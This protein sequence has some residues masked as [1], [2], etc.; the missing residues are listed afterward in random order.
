MAAKLFPISI[1]TASTSLFYKCLRK[2]SLGDDLKSALET[3]RMSKF[4]FSSS[5]MWCPMLSYA[6]DLCCFLDYLTNPSPQLQ[7]FAY[8]SQS[9]FL[10][11]SAVQ[12]SIEFSPVFSVWWAAVTLLLP[13]PWLSSP[14]RQLCWVSW[15][16]GLRWPIW[17]NHWFRV[18][19]RMP[20][21]DHAHVGPPVKS[22]WQPVASS[23]QGEIAVLTV[24]QLSV[25][26]LW[27]WGNVTGNSY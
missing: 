19:E 15:R 23:V 6:G 11:S 27:E 26:H 10:P 25:R 21:F 16:V 22:D 20:S 7:N 12:V 13:L 8:P 2:P 24:W 4:L 18:Y 5:T 17:M 1:V 14:G 9:A 3:L